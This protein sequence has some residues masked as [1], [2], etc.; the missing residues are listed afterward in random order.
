MILC[1][2]ASIDENDELTSEL[3]KIKEKKLEI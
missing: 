1:I 3:K 2:L